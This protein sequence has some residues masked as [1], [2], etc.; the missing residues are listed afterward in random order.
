M[1][2]YMH[3]QNKQTWIVTRMNQTDMNHNT[4]AS[5]N[6]TDMNQSIQQT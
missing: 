4:H 6:Q 3:E 2:H 1:N 5:V